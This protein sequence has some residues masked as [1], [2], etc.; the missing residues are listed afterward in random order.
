MSKIKVLVVPSDRTGVGAFRSVN[1][2]IAL[3]DM[4]AEEFSVDIDYEPQL[5][6]DEWLK[7]YDIIHY[8]RT[9]GAFENMPEILE[10]TKRLG[11]V[12]IMD[13]DDYWAPGQHHPAYLIIKNN[14]LDEKILGNI[15]V[16]QNVT[17]TT[18]LFADEI[19]KYNKNWMVRWFFSLRRFKIT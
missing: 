2:H 19:K 6:N 17:T 1:P 4:Y 7:Q 3:E 10:R 12:T 13:L 5:G 9:L 8:H 14:K 11:I 15:K 16:A 18:D